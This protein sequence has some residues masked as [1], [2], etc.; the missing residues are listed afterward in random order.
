MLRCRD[1][2][3]IEEVLRM[4]KSV[5]FALLLL[6]AMFGVACGGND[7][8]AIESPGATEPTDEPTEEPTEDCLDGTG[9]A[10][11]TITMGDNFFD[12]ECFSVDQSAALDLVNDGSAAHTFTI[13][14][15]QIDVEFDPG[16]S[17]TLEGPSP[18]E[19]GEYVYYC[20]FHGSPGGGA[21]MSGTL[22]VV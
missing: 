13:P 4:R 19:P 3:P 15:S 9:E 7:N 12:P 10:E 8:P 16:E 2:F 21:G 18:L 6:L 22:T 20:R 17:Q 14:E 11:V 5:A 1:P